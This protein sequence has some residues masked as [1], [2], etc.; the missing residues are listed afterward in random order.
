VLGA[1]NTFSGTTTVAGG[2]ARLG[3]GGD[4]GSVAGPITVVAADNAVVIDRSDDL[5]LANTISGSGG[6]FKEGGNTVTLTGANSYTAGTTLFA[7]TLVVGDGGTAGSIAP[8]GPLD[9]AVGTT[10]VFDRNDD[11][12]F[13][14]TVSGEGTLT[15]RGDGRLVLSQ[16][17]SI[18]PSFT[19]RAE[20]GV[21][22]LDRSGSSITGMLGTG[23]V[24]ELTGGTLELFIDPVLPLTELTVMGDS[25]VAHALCELAPRVGF[26]V[27]AVPSAFDQ[28]PSGGW[29]IVAT[30]GRGDVPALRAALE[31]Q[32][33]TVWFVASE[34]KG[35]VLKDSLKA[36][37]LP[38]AAVD[39]IVAPAGTPIGA[40]TPEEIA[41]SVLG[42]VIAAHRQAPATRPNAQPIE[43][44]AAVSASPTE[45]AP[46]ASC[47]GGAKAVPVLEPVPAM[48]SAGK[49]SCCGG[50]A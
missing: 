12:S 24:V 30:Q 36:S 44:L 7:G 2:W 27:R 38:K 49:G 46:K 31:A 41:L 16:S 47:C 8:S 5:T 28:A 43:A 21:V 33:R 14:G 40:Q 32:A 20:A 3:A 29:V 39:A 15:Q 22:T 35:A 48:T 6:L 11:I 10:L 42:A 37:G 45:A 17:G 9:L 19:L 23:N 34:R 25:P 13:R 1:N 50:G 26:S 4:S 18:G